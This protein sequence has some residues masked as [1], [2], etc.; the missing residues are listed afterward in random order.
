L[1]SGDKLEP[2]ASLELDPDSLDS[3]DKEQVDLSGL[4]AYSTGSVVLDLDL[5]QALPRG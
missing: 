4:K 3:G 1:D 2:E 5:D